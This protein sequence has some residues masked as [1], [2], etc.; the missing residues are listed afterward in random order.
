LKQNFPNPFN[1][2]TSITYT[3]RSSGP[4]QLEVFDHL[5]RSVGV[6]VDGVVGAGEYTLQFDAASL[7]SGMYLYRLSAGNQTITRKM[8]LLK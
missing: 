8:M 1:P 4:I 2:T 3:V 7:P 5:G 6:L